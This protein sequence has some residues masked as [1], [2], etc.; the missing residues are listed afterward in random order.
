MG[1]LAR[2]YLVLYNVAQACGWLTVLAK[3]S[4]ASLDDATGAYDACRSTLMVFQLASFAEI[5]HAV[6]GLTPTPAAAALAQWSGRT[7]C[8]KCALDAVKTS[9]AS[10]AATA[11]VF[12]WA[13]TEMVRYQSYVGGLI[14]RSPKWLTWSRYTVFVPLYP[15]GAAAEM[16]LMYDARAHARKTKMYAVTMPNAYNFAFDYVTFLNALL[17]AYPFLFYTL[18]RYMFAQRRK[19]LGK[20][21]EN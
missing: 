2:R 12:A 19:K 9:H 11:L 16:K 10:V 21:K 1:A 8:L 18:Y 17:V 3:A 13:L 7:H 5:A 4:R 14:G 15:L 6:A 20:A